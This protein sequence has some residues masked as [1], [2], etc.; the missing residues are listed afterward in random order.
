MSTQRN[1]KISEQHHPL[2]HR[3]GSLKLMQ[4]NYPNKLQR[5]LTFKV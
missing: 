2:S 3:I 5:S 4:A 1:T